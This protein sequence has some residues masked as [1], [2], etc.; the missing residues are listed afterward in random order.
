MT[1]HDENTVRRNRF[2]GFIKI[3]YNFT[4]WLNAF[5]RVGADVTHLR[6]NR[7]LKPGRHFGNNWCNEN[8]RE[9]FW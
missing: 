6:D 7:I 5:V 3:N 8:C 9:F 2:L 1:L 4:D